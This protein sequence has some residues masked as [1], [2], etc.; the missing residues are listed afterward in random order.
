MSGIHCCVKRGVAV[1]IN[2]SPKFHSRTRTEV[3]DETFQSDVFDVTLNNIITQLTT[4][5]PTIGNIC[6]DFKGIV[7]RI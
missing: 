3:T 4:R 7:K 1:A 5:L 2:V 6:N